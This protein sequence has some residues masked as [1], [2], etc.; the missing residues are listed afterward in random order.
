MAALLA[1]FSSSFS[2]IISEPFHRER[3][4]LN[5][6]PSCLVPAIGFSSSRAVLPQKLSM[7]RTSVIV[8]A[9][10]KKKKDKTKEDAHSFVVKPDEATGPFPEAVLLKKKVAKEDGRI[11]PEFADA[12]EEKLYDFMKLQLESDLALER[13]RHYEVVYLIHEDHAEEVENVISK[14]QDFIREKKGKIWRLNNWGM[15]RLAYKI[16]KA[17]S[18][19]YVLM[20]FEIEAKLINDFKR[21][22]DKDERIIRHLVIKRDKA[23]TEY[24]P[25]PMEF[26]VLSQNLPSEDDE[27]E[28]EYDDEDEDEYDEEE[29]GEND[30][31]EEAGENDDEYDE[32]E[33]Y[34]EEEEEYDDGE[35][36]TNSHDDNDNVEDDVIFIDDDGDDDDAKDEKDARRGAIRTTKKEKIR[37]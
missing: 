35:L 26:H 23:I 33:D 25:P 20:N 11:A 29:A 32:E 6:K 3:I 36:V 13:M 1:N 30:D 14:V 9:R 28:D 2:R 7:A 12:E 34:D 22:L 21:M 15:R 31:E 27:D 5:G 24:C 10:G 4:F 19:N 17:T 8:G 16:K 37:R 18:A